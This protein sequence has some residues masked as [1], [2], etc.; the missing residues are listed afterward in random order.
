MTSRPMNTTAS[1]QKSR[2][3]FWKFWTGQTISSF[4]SSFTGFALPLLIFKLTNSPV[5]LALTVATSVIPYLFF[6]LTIGVFVDRVNRKRLMI[7]TDIGR[8]LVIASLPLLTSFGL[9]SVWWIYITALVNSTLSMA[10]DAANFAAIPSLVDQKKLVTAN[11]H[12]QASYSA[13]SVAGPFLAGL[14][15]VVIPIST[16]FIFDA[17]SFLMSAGSLAL[18]VVSFNT[19]TTVKKEHTSIRQDVLEGLHLI[20]QNSVLRWLTLMLLFI[21][22]FGPTINVQLVLF[23]KDWL[24]AKDTQIGM[25]FSS[26]SV[27]VIITSLLATRL[28]KYLSF[29]IALIGTTL[30]GGLVTA[31]LSLTHLYW[32]ALFLWM[33]RG[34]VDVFFIINAYSLTQSLVAH[35]LLG[36]VI[37]FTRVL[38]WP[39][40][41]V[42]AL[43]GGFAIERTNVGLIYGIVGLLLFL[44][45][46]AF[47]FTPLRHAE[48][49]VSQKGQNS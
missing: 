8:A 38:T 39:T 33:V 20:T 26:G 49:F 21:N 5:N 44:I 37:T 41:S 18:V 13:A 45:A 32:L 19:K 12:I 15:L 47:S 36:R 35:E 14:L 46:L 10:F 30:L 9:L 3:D 48:H 22:F 11:G 42:G 29:G 6:G 40:A 27:G 4:G 1:I 2:S 17:L 25:L 31:V 24:H 43:I 28:R 7:S 34:G 23:A 16:L